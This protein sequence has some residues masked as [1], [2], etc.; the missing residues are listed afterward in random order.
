MSRHLLAMVGA[1]ALLGAA[2]PDS[3]AWT[4]AANGTAIAVDAAEIGPGVT[5]RIEH[6][7][8]PQAAIADLRFVEANWY[9]G[10]DFQPT[11]GSPRRVRA[12]LEYPAGRLH[13]IRWRTGTTLTI[14]PAANLMSEPVRMK[15]PRGARFWT[16]WSNAG[17]TVPR[18]PMQRLPAPPSAI[19]RSDGNAPASAGIIATATADTAFFGPSAILGTVRKRDARGAVILGDS[20]AFGTGDVTASGPA[21]GSGY[22]ARALDPL[23]GYTRLARGGQS[24]SDVAGAAS[25]A[26][27]R[28]L[29][30]LRYSDAV[31]EHGVNDLRLGRTPAQL[32]ADQ[33]TIRRL[34]D[35]RAKQWQMTL[36]PRTLS[37]DGYLG[38]D[39]QTAKR[40]GTMAA[41]ATVNAAI[42]AEAAPR[43]TVIDIAD[44]AMTRRDS[45][46]W[47][48]PYPP[49][50]DGTHPTSAKAAALADA[51][52]A[53][54]S[55]RLSASFHPAISPARFSSA[56]VSTKRRSS[57]QV[58]ASASRSGHTPPPARPGTP[59]PAPWSR[60][61]PAARPDTP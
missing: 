59:R 51:M 19:G 44:A 54:L 27:K 31:F 55:A 56:I 35:P 53:Q 29:A 39:R 60:P 20:I 18:W 8:S 5:S 57:A 16:R 11:P 4:I 3:G 50:L 42:R 61:P 24:A 10:P 52:R 58:A 34:V 9:Y 41:L 38:A 33:R 28:F 36:T 40:D 48:G 45:G 26:P 12:W 22:P 23:F 30:L 13:P 17:A 6:R 21:G 15:I 43:L 32:L 46:I 14:G 2:P 25:D 49:V 47:S 37:D 7:A 1:L